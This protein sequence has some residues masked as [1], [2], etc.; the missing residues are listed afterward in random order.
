MSGCSLEQLVVYLTTSPGEMMAKDILLEAVRVKAQ[1]STR[2]LL[3]KL[4]S[5]REV[6]VRCDRILVLSCLLSFVGYLL[7]M[8]FHYTPSPV[9]SEKYTHITCISYPRYSVFMPFIA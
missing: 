6:E 5:F 1:V 9:Q 3:I 2:Y 4:F 7:L 8:L